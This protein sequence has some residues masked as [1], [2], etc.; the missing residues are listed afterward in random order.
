MATNRQIQH[1]IRRPHLYSRFM[2]TGEL[3]R[4]VLPDSPLIRAIEKIAPRDRARM[5]GFVVSS[6]LGYSGS[7][8]FHSVAQALLWLA[9]EP[10]VF[11]SFPAE[12]WRIKA[13]GKALSFGDIAAH[14]GMVPEDIAKRYAPAP[15]P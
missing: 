1:M 11:G 12:S 7:R 10:E 13:F 14:C 15:R 3:P 4:G 5:T 8:R 9:P 6:D 2:L